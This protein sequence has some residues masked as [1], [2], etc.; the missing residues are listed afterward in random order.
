[1]YVF[2]GM[3]ERGQANDIH[4][5]NL[6][7]PSPRAARC[8]DASLHCP[9]FSAAHGAHAHAGFAPAA[10]L[11]GAAEVASPAV[12]WDCAHV[13]VWFVPVAAGASASHS[14]AC[15]IWTAEHW[16]WTTPEV[17]GA[18]LP[19]CG[20]S[21]TMIGTKMLILGGFSETTH[22]LDPSCEFRWRCLVCSVEAVIARS[23]PHKPRQSSA[24]LVC[25]V[26]AV[27]GADAVLTRC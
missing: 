15:C 4:C 9:L 14:D 19:R 13:R 5:L 8:G 26:P 25:V 23:T 17:S 6:G 27:L 21:A 2:G 3:T 18:P 24:P 1:M 20:H 12:G 11:I 7:A 16:T 10:M 22:I